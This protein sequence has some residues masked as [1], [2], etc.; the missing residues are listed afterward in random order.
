M[1]QEAI[2]HLYTVF[3]QYRPRRPVHGCPCCTPEYD[4]ER[5]NTIPLR[6]L[7]PD[8]LDSYLRN[9]MTTW[10][11]EE[12]FKYFLPRL[13]E[14]FAADTPRVDE[15]FLGVKIGKSA[16]WAEWLT[17]EREAVL[18]FFRALW[19]K[20]LASQEDFWL[21][22]DILDVLV[23]LGVDP[24]PYLEQLWQQAACRPLAYVVNR[25]VQYDQR[26]GVMRLGDGRWSG[27]TPF[28]RD[29]RTL[30]CLEDG[31][32]T[33]SGEDWAPEVSDAADAL[34]AALEHC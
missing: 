3:A 20:V 12:D 29:P 19:A 23:A 4:Q 22:G 2:E 34:R 18:A 33:H 24:R 10:G 7:P 17:A 5:L 16:G 25:C 13:L 31:Y 6:E 28:L 1:L 26:R 15:Y 9:A 21:V 27:I 8:L 11:T 32:L 30:A 14:W